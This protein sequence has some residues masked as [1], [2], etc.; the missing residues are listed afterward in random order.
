MIFMPIW[1]YITSFLLFYAPNML[2]TALTKEDFIAW[3]LYTLITIAPAMERE[4]FTQVIYGT[5]TVF[6]N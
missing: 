5:D 1:L 4:T 3:F 2:L 6:F